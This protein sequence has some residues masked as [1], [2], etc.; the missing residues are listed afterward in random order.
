MLTHIFK[1]QSVLLPD[2]KES[3]EVSLH[4]VLNIELSEN[5]L[6]LAFNFSLSLGYVRGIPDAK[7]FWSLCDSHHLASSTSIF[8]EYSETAWKNHVFDSQ[9]SKR[10]AGHT[11]EEE[12]QS[13]G[14]SSFA[15]STSSFG[16]Y[17]E[18]TDD[19]DSIGETEP[20][21][22][23]SNSSRRSIDVM[24]VRAWPLTRS[25]EAHVERENKQTIDAGL[26]IDKI[27]EVKGT[28]EKSVRT[29][30]QE[31]SIRTIFRPYPGNSEYLRFSVAAYQGLMIPICV[32]SVPQW[33]HVITQLRDLSVVFDAYEKLPCWKKMFAACHPCIASLRNPKPHHLPDEVRFGSPFVMGSKW[34]ISEGIRKLFIAFTF[35]VELQRCNDERQNIL[36]RITFTQFGEIFIDSAGGMQCTSFTSIPMLCREQKWQKKK[37]ELGS[38]SNI[39][40]R[41]LKTFITHQPRPQDNERYFLDVMCCRKKADPSVPP[42]DLLR[43]DMFAELDRGRIV[44][45]SFLKPNEQ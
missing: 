14:S 16:V 4:P 3:V 42:V 41:D 37:Y 6:T 27:G 15:G 35:R 29:S 34:L 31:T 9:E 7:W 36:F 8:K 22:V 13:H 39:S 40:S 2:V 1:S 45:S 38:H 18:Y 28:K 21:P 10:A 44:I 19:I 25:N 12:S 20:F 30:K 23:R 26:G 32:D 24:F 43:A 17:T 5:E 33:T 11:T